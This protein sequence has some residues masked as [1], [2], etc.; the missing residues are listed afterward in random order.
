MIISCET[1][2]GAEGV[3]SVIVR[4][5]TP[6]SLTASLTNQQEMIKHMFHKDTKPDHIF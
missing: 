6:A 3:G 1:F 5:S 2:Y 4:K